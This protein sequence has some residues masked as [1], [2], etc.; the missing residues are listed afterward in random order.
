MG[1]QDNIGKPPFAQAAGVSRGNEVFVVEE[2]KGEP[3]ETGSG[4]LAAEEH[5]RVSE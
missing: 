4:L 3:G 5:Q 1:G 2:D